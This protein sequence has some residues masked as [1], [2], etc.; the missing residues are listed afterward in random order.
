L[1]QGARELLQRFNTWNRV[2]VFN[3][4]NIDQQQAAAFLNVSLRQILPDP[5]GTK[6]VA[7]HHVGDYSKALWLAQYG[8]SSWSWSVGIEVA[9]A[10]ALASALGVKHSELVRRSEKPS[11]GWI[12]S[13][14]CPQFNFSLPEMQHY[15]KATSIVYQ[16]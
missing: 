15:A 13:E 6:S 1:G 11:F 10:L 3:A 2:I 4:R 5:K 7:D 14:E 12:S 8:A 9:N 16:R